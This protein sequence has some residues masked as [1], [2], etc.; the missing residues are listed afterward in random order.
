M[1][2]TKLTSYFSLNPLSL[3]LS[4]ECYFVRCTYESSSSPLSRYVDHNYASILNNVYCHSVFAKKN[5]SGSSNAALPPGAQPGK[6]LRPPYPQPQVLLPHIPNTVGPSSIH[7][8]GLSA[9]GGGSI[10]DESSCE[11]EKKDDISKVVQTAELSAFTC[12]RNYF[13]FTLGIVFRIC[14]LHLG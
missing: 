5:Y 13:S 9:A 10:E 2:L 4:Y 6:S 8:S 14:R 12:C 11:S 7:G 3:S 1:K